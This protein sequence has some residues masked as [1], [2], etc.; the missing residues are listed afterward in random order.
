LGEILNF[1]FIALPWTAVGFLLV[2]YDLIFNIWFNDFWAGGNVFLIVYSVYLIVQYILS[3]GLFWEIDIWLQ[4]TFFIRLFSLFS[5]YL[6]M[7]YFLA[8]FVIL[9][10]LI[11]DMDGHEITWDGMFTAFFI[12]YNLLLH[13]PVLVI[14]FG[15]AVKELSMEFWQ[16]ANDFAGSGL[17][18]T[19]LGFHNISDLLIALTNWID[20][21]WWIE[22]DDGFKWDRMY[23]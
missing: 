15:I 4:Y 10:V 1:V 6:Y 14:N 13:W 5:A 19:S 2:V 9:M 16:F 8:C 12:S 20:P 17:D 22:E 7:W 21:M 23:E 18:D 11:N 3:L